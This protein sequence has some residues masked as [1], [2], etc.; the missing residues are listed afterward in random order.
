LREIFVPLTL[1][2]MSEESPEE[3]RQALIELRVRRSVSKAVKREAAIELA[4]TAEAIKLAKQR[5]SDLSHEEIVALGRRVRARMKAQAPDRYLAL[6]QT[7]ESKVDYEER[8]N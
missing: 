5:K 1:L 6:I 3:L 4:F 8:A 7:I 2:Y